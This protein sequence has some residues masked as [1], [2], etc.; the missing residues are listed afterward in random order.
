MSVSDE[1]CGRDE[2]R[3]GRASPDGIC[4]PSSL[5]EDRAGLREREER[6]ELFMA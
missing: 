3:D 4:T 5:S 2:S 1:R 6:S